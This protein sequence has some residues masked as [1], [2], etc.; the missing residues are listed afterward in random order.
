MAD[1]D[2]VLKEAINGQ[3]SE[4]E[5]M[6]SVIEQKARD[7]SKGSLSADMMAND[8]A[9]L[10]KLVKELGKAPSGQ[11]DNRAFYA[12]VEALESNSRVAEDILDKVDATRQT[13]DRLA[14]EGKPFSATAA[15]R[16]LHLIAS[17][18]H[19]ILTTADLAAP[20][21]ASDLSALATQMDHI[22]GLFAGAK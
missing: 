12:S 13:V 20:Y 2:N 11:S 1:T 7:A 8:I 5:R 15:R 6:I 18:V 17:K 14:S 3:I 10:R 16:D 9:N 22:H 21:V 4:I 19:N